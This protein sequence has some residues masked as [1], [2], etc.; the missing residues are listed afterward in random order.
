MSL[1][2]VKEYVSVSIKVHLN[3]TYIIPSASLHCQLIHFSSLKQD[4]GGNF[5]L[6]HNNLFESSPK[7]KKV[8]VLLSLH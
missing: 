2:F 7:N 5:F 6:Q 8:S 4:H 3:K 1:G